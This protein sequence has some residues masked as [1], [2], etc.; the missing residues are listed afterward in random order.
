MKQ[1]TTKTEHH[2]IDGFLVS[3]VKNQKVDKCEHQ[4]FLYICLSPQYSNTNYF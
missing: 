1:G 4:V 3:V 2:S